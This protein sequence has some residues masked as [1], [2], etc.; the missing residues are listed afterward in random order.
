MRRMSLLSGF[1]VAGL[2]IVV[3]AYAKSSDDKSAKTGDTTVVAYSGAQSWP[4][5]TSAEILK[6]YAVPV[7]KGLPDKQYKVVGRIIDS[8]SGVE[9]VGKAFEDTFGGQKHRL[10]ECTNQAKQQ[11]GDAVVVTDDDRVLK[12]LNLSRK[13]AKDSSP[14]AKDQHSVVLIVKF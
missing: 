9:E 10:R 7:Y 2:I 1:V 5:G 11:G 14:L 13:E 4:T 8:R 3:S 6:D 12:T